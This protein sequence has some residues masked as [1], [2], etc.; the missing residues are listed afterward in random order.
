MHSR[1]QIS[2]YGSIPQTHSRTAPPSRL[3]SSTTPTSASSP[4]S[5][6][7]SST[8]VAAPRT[9]RSPLVVRRPSH[10]PSRLTRASA[11]TWTASPSVAVSPPRAGRRRPR[12]S[13][14]STRSHQVVRRFTSPASRKPPRPATSRSTTAPASLVTSSSV[15]VLLYPWLCADCSRLYSGSPVARSPS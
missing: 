10:K 3:T 2:A 13:R 1:K 4:A 11:S 8:A 5:A 7:R 6:T 15:L 14:F 12:P 9:F